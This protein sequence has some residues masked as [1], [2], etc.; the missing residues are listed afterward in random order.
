MK[1]TILAVILGLFLTICVGCN[2]STDSNKTSNTGENTGS[3]NEEQ[4]IDSK[5]N[6]QSSSELEKIDET[7]H[8]YLV[9]NKFSLKIDLEENK[10]TEELLNILKQKQINLKLKENGGFEKYGDLG[11]NLT[12]SNSNITGNSG[13]IILYNGNQIC[14][15]YGTNTY[16]YTKLGHINI[17][18]KDFKTILG[19]GDI[20]AK[21][22]YE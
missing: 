13:D 21:L 14:V 18:D 3:N 7:K 4:S 11:Y 16:S 1:K 19:T 5:S 12:T 6:N 17:N 22:I 8:V 9:I 20:E 10:A 2:Q 15:F